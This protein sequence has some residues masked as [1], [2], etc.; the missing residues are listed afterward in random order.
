MIVIS[1][2]NG[3]V[4]LPAAIKK[5]VQG[6]SAVDAVEIATRIVE[7]NMADQTVGRGGLPNVLGE[8][9]LD[10][11]IMDGRTLRAGAVGSVQGYVHVITLA[12]HVM[13]ETPHVFLVADGAERLAR[14]IGMPLDHPLTSEAK[15][16]WQDGLR[17]YDPDLNVDTL[18]KRND[19]RL[20]VDA[21]NQPMAG[22]KPKPHGTVNLIARDDDGN[23]ATAVSTSGWAWSYPGRLG[24]SPV[25]GAGS[26]ADNRWGAVASTGTGE[27]TLRTAAARSIILYMKMGLS[28]DDAQHE[29]MKDLKDLKDGYI[30]HIA[31]IGLNKD[32]HHTGYT[33]RP[34]E[35]Y[36]FMTDQMDHPAEIDMKKLEA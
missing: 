25:I 26:Y 19:L 36:A 23:L 34:D 13:E 10:A 24:D 12:R 4:G 18:P 29:A 8:V 6:G 14:E 32:G 5:L 15:K 9:R 20:V 28:L 7:R 31:I 17:K 16:V 33:F 30:E 3:K 35:R 22:W 21:M 2:I 1:S 11:S 27:V